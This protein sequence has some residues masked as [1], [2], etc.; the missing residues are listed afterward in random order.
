MLAKCKRVKGHVLT[1]SI[2]FARR[3]EHIANFMRSVRALVPCASA[4]N[5]AQRGYLL[6][7]PY[8][9]SGQVLSGI[10]RFTAG[11]LFK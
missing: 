2:R 1:E 3:R 6:R 11:R 4:N 5:S 7:E 8:F 9:F 10:S